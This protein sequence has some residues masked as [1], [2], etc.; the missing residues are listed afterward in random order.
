[1]N[2]SHSRQHCEVVFP[3]RKWSPQKVARKIFNKAK[4]LYHHEMI[5]YTKVSQNLLKPLSLLVW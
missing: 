4:G 5:M 3:Q 2:I 1:M